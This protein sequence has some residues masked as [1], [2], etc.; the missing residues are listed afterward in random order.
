LIQTGA[1][2]DATN[3]TKD[4][5]APLIAGVPANP[6]YDFYDV[7]PEVNTMAPSSATVL[8]HSI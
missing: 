2:S 4:P 7:M 5:I 8:R 6:R 3:F 1:I